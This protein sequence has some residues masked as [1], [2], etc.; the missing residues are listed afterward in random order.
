MDFNV[1]YDVITVPR[2]FNSTLYRLP[3]LTSYMPRDE[4]KLLVLFV[5]VI[6]FS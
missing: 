4:R 6:Y 2:C 1:A 3:S 5:L